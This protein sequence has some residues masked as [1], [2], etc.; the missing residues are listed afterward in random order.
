MNNQTKKRWYSWLIYIL[1][2][3]VVMQ[4]AN[5]WKT[6][7]VQKDNLSEFTGVLMDGS[8]FSIAEFAGEPVLFHFWA[9]WCPICELENGTIQSISQDYPVISIASW[10]EG[11]PEVKA[12]MRENQ[13]NFSVILDTSGELAQSFGLKGVPTSFIVDPNGEIMFVETG[14]STEIGLRLRL[15]LSTL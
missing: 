3:V 8:E 7:D 1:L 6:R 13:L 11:E 15:W 2:F 10:S 14:Y 5:W 12:Y 9:T 4:A